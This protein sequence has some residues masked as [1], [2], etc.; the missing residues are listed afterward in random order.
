MTNWRG[1]LAPRFAPAGPLIGDG[2]NH[3]SRIPYQ[4]VRRGDYP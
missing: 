3:N 2:A 4:G 1:A